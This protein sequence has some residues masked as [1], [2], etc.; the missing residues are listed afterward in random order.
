[1]FV[2]Q[3]P[4]SAKGGHAFGGSTWDGR[5]YRC[6]RSEQA[7]SSGDVRLIAIQAVNQETG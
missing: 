6:R 5:R 3:K 2:S 1:M 4:S 7:L